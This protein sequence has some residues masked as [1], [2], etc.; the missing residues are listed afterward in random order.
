MIFLASP[1]LLWSTAH[2][3]AAPYSVSVWQ[4]KRLF[5]TDLEIFVI[6]KRQKC[7]GLRHI[8]SFLNRISLLYL[9]LKFLLPKG[10]F[11]VC[12]WH[13]C[14]ISNTSNSVT[15]FKQN[16]LQKICLYIT[17]KLYLCPPLG[18]NIQI[19]LWN[20]IKI[21][22]LLISSSYTIVLERLGGPHSKPYRLL[23][24][25]FLEYSREPNPGVLDGRRANHYTKNVLKLR[26]WDKHFANH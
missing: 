22:T 24:E 8:S 2:W 3:I 20:F 19:Y 4:S 1:P 18:G 26:L 25:K 12:I 15:Y 9:N 5:S 16:P 6:D 14:S 23:P 17:N 21:S 11:L 10:K 13:P 7:L